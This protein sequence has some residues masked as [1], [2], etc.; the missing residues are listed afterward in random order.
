M[1]IKENIILNKTYAFAIAIVETY[2]SLK[3]D[4]KVFIPSKQLLRSGTSVGANVEEA[5][6]GYSKKDFR[7]KMSIAYKEARE[8]MYWLKLLRD[9]NFIG[10][11]QSE[12]LI[13]DCE[14]ILRILWK[15]LKS[16]E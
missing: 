15:I 16:S 11:Q 7:H 1:S 13:N 5:N 6:G 8:T 9:T 2:K 12:I 10:P 4:S 14:E 3:S